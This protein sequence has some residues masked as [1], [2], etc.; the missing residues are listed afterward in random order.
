MITMSD[1][2][3]GSQVYVRARWS[4][5]LSRFT[6]VAVCDNVAGGVPGID[7]VTS[8]GDCYWA[9]LDQVHQVAVY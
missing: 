5:T 1:L 3:E 2:R 6:V 9:Y 7:Y 8:D 4:G